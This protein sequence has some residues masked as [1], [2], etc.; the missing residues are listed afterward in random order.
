MRG[1]RDGEVAG[2]PPGDQCPLER[3][4]V[5]FLE[6]GGKFVE[7]VV[8]IA[9]GESDGGVS[10]EN[11]IVY[12][13]KRNLGLGIER[14]GDH[15]DFAADGYFQFSAGLGAHAREEMKRLSYANRSLAR[16]ADGAAF[17]AIIY[18]RS[19]LFPEI[20]GRHKIRASFRCGAAKA[21]FSISAGVR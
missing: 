1:C 4:A 2:C 9:P 18:L 13:D 20:Q 7:R 11:A 10:I 12:I 17:A 15:S 8:A 16:C 6:K 21:S 5:G 3:Q 14:N 19:E